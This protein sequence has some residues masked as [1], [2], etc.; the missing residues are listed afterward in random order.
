MTDKRNFTSIVSSL[1][2]T[3]PFV[4]PEAIERRVGREFEARLGANESAFGV[5]PKAVEAMRAASACVS[6]YNDPENHD[7]R[8]AL[9]ARHSVETHEIAIVAGIDDLLGLIVRLFVDRGESVVASL[10]AYPTFV[11]HVNGFGCKLVTRPYR[12]GRNDYGALLDA[13]EEA[14]ARLL[15]LSNPDNPAGT[16]LTR[17]EIG[18]LIVR[19]PERCVLIL[20]E[21]YAE[22]A[23]DEAIPPIHPIHPRVIRARTFSKVYGMAGARVGYAVCEEEIASAFNKVRLHFGVNLVA[24]RGALAALKDR[25]FVENVV[26]Q[27][28]EGRREY[29]E[30]AMTLG[31]PTLP[32]GTN[33]VTFDAGSKERAEGILAGLQDRGVFIRKPGHPPVDRYFRVTVGRPEERALFAERLSGLLS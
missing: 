24:Q 14:D 7:L 22:F 19:L 3:I 12:E 28:A 29:E 16:W 17:S 15:Y 25:T 9:A 11:Y 33:F 27:V 1:P 13:V 4:G 6:W 21:A 31:L 20:D 32:S 10:G 2:S 26:A 23:P 5:S 30:L 18:E 8:A